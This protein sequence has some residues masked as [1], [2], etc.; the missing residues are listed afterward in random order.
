MDA[1]STRDTAAAD[2][3]WSRQKAMA[4]A[5]LARLAVRPDRSA[6]RRAR[7]IWVSGRSPASAAAA[8]A[9]S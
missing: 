3:L 7:S 6:S 2:S 4:S 1:H 5:M 8:V 9:A